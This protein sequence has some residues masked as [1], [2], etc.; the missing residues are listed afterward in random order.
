MHDIQLSLMFIF[1]IVIPTFQALNG[2]NNVFST[3]ATNTVISFIIIAAYPKLIPSN[4]QWSF[5]PLSSSN[6]II[7]INGNNTSKYSFSPN[8]L[9]LTINN[10]Q[11]A[12]IGEYKIVG[13]NNAGSGEA[14]ITLEDVYGKLMIFYY[15]FV[16]ICCD[17]S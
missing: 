9:T 5:T 16:L 2:I 4:I 12:D 14:T 10:S 11:S 13:F 7:E 17:F 8:K 1:T 15:Y 3:R 6:E